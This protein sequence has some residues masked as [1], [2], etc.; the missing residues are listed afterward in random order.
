MLKSVRPFSETIILDIYT[1]KGEILKC[2]M[3][4]DIGDFGYILLLSCI[5]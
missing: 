2:I 1:E 5:D 3:N 4:Y